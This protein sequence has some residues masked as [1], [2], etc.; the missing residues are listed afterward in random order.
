[1]VFLGSGV[2][3]KLAPKFDVSLYAF[4]SPST[5]DFKISLQTHSF[6][7]YEDSFLMQPSKHKIQPRFSAYLLFVLFKQSTFYYPIFLTLQQCTL[8]PAYVYQKY[9]RGHCLWNFRT[10]IFLSPLPSHY[11]LVLF[12][13]VLPL[14][15][16]TLVFERC[17]LSVAVADSWPCPFSGSVILK[18]GLSMHFIHFPISVLWQIVMFHVI[19]YISPVLGS[20]VGLLKSWSFSS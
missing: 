3:S 9:E 7:R 5:A 15:A 2:N 12:V 1:M 13:F 16:Y 19:N 4:Y 20:A 11:T 6:Q 10:V 14:S 17:Q 18:M 8:R